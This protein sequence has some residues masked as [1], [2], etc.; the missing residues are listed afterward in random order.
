M[1][2]PL[3]HDSGE[4]HHQPWV[5]YGI[6]FSCALVF[7]M[8]QVLNREVSGNAERLVGGAAAPLEAVG[9]FVSLLIRRARAFPLPDPG[10][11]RGQPFK[12]FR[13]LAGYEAQVLRAERPVVDDIF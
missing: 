11:A 4:V 10:S 2:I 3:S 13:D 8:T 5:T 9:Q 12:I 6:I 1:I 7:L